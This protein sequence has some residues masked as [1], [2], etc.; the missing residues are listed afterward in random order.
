MHLMYGLPNGFLTGSLLDKDT[1]DILTRYRKYERK[2]RAAEEALAAQILKQRLEK[3]RK[4]L[5]KQKLKKR[6]EE[7][8]EQGATAEQIVQ[9][10]AQEIEFEFTEETKQLVEQDLDS[11]YSKV[12]DRQIAK[13]KANLLEVVEKHYAQIQREKSIAEDLLKQKSLEMA[14]V[15]R[16]KKNVKKAK[17]LFML[18]QSE[19]EL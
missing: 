9:Q 1:S 12:L 17:I 11:F 15:K 13:L 19:D 10:V 7:Q 4:K 16:R 18:L 8:I 14:K 6:I 5:E 2:E 3:Q